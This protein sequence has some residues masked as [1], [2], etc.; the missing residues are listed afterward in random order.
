MLT[1][2]FAKHV[3]SL[4]LRE[5][6]GVRERSGARRPFIIWGGS[7]R[8]MIVSAKRVPQLAMPCL[9]SIPVLGLCAELPDHGER[10]TGWG[11][12]SCS[13]DATKIAVDLAET[14][15]TGAKP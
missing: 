4:A 14:H 15:P 12:P 8:P 7:P 6:V 10:E 9:L 3:C 2:N 1:M 11:H 13:P 5:R